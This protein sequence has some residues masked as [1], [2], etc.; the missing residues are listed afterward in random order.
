MIVNG[1]FA[2]GLS[3]NNVVENVK[4]I[5]KITDKNIWI[6]A[7]TRLRTSLDLVFDLNKVEKFLENVKPYVI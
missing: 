2:G 1:G 4:S 6:D 7:E 5:K 3:P